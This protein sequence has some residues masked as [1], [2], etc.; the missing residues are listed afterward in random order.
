MENISESLK[1]FLNLTMT[2]ALIARRFDARLSIH[3]LSLNDFMILF[4]LSKAPDEKLRR[5]DLAEKVGLSASAITKKI[6]PLEKIGMVTKEANARDARVSFVKLAEGGNRVL[7]EALQSAEMA[8]KE[9]YPKEKEEK[10]VQ[11]NQVL[12]ELGGSVQ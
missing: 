9:L 10:L 6:T 4:H 5:I 3:S 12:I 7:H 11:S 1:F 8:A 2:Q